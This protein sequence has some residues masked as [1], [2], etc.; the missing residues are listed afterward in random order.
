MRITGV[1]Y[2]PQGFEYDPQGFEYD[3]Q[4]FEYDPQ[5]FEYDPMGSNTIPFCA[6][7]TRLECGPHGSNRGPTPAHIRS[8]VTYD[9]M[10]QIRPRL[11]QI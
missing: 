4:G 10:S 2:D 11:G 8:R 6:P 5:G 3:P 9:P 7:S 1:N